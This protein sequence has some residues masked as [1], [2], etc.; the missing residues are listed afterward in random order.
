MHVEYG[1]VVP[2]PLVPAAFAAMT[3]TEALLALLKALAPDV[4]DSVQVQPLQCRAGEYVGWKSGPLN[5]TYEACL[6]ATAC[7]AGQQYE[8]LQLTATSNRVCRNVTS[9]VLGQSYQV[10]RE[11]V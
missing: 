2:L 5:S 3:D 1:A 9:C 8:A 4:F 11:S 10:R 7:A 6:P